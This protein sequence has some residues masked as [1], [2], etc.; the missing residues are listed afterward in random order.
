MATVRRQGPGFKRLRLALAELDGVEGKVGYFESSR[1]KDGTPVAYVAAVHEIG[2]AP[3]GIPPR[4]TLGP[5]IDANR[6]AYAKQFGQGAKA[7]LDGRSTAMDVMET[8]VLVAAG[9]VGAAIG[10][11]QDP[12][13]K[14]ETVR[15]KGFSKPLV[16]TRQMIQAVTGV[17]ERKT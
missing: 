13:L 6:E 4:P 5:T 2:F 3:G 11:L 17:A 9:D 8:M 15:R 7:I 1:Y 14:P 10:A 12:P 16:E